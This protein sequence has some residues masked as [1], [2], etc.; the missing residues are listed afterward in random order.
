MK[1]VLF[2]VL[3]GAGT[4]VHA[5]QQTKVNDPIK[6]CWVVENNVK[7]P[8]KQVVKFYDADQQM[9][10]QEVYD[11]K[12]LK[13]AKKGIRRMLDS[14]LVTVLNQSQSKEGSTL[15]NVIRYKH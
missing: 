8:G 9:L 14:A 2:I 10:Y 13:I 1:K 6:G 11:K 5:Q 15:A 7:S 3:L 4:V 12:V